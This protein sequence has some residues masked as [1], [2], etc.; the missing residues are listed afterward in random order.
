MTTVHSVIMALS[1]RILGLCTS[2]TKIVP[3][4]EL[5]DQQFTLVWNKLRSSFRPLMGIIS[6]P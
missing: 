4:T 1:F 5:F 6:T 2:I 3:L